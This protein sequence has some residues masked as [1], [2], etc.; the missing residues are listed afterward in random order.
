MGISTDIL[1]ESNKMEAAIPPEKAPPPS[2][3]EQIAARRPAFLAN[4]RLDVEKMESALAV[5]D[6]AL[7]QSIG[8][9]AKG[10]GTGYGFPEISRIGLTIETAA[11]ARN[12][13]EVAKAIHQFAISIQAA[14]PDQSA[15]E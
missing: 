15:G 1:L 6:F 9:N 8:H 13:L 14:C 5:Q 3:A 11:K 7:I 10:I 12:G 4:R 2:I